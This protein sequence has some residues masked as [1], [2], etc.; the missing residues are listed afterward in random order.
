MK[1]KIVYLTVNGVKLKILLRRGNNPIIILLHGTPGQMSNWKHVLGFLET[2]NYTVVVPD[3]RGYGG[4]EKPEVVSIDDYVEDL[5]GIMESLDLD[6]TMTLVAG[7]SF[8]CVVAME[9]IAKYNDIPATL[10]VGPPYELKMDFI[11]KIIVHTPPLFWKPLFFKNNPLTRRLYR[12]LFFSP[13][14]PNKIFQDFM[15]DN[16]KYIENLPAHVFRYS[17]FF[18][19]WR[20][21]EK[22][23]EARV[24]AEIIVGK[25]DIVTSPETAEKINEL[26]PGSKLITVEDAGHM[27]LYEKPDVV[28]SSIIRLANSI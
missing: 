18:D 16:T 17:R 10:L 23:R 8:G 5:R 22:L 20:A 7:H 11:D 26:I 28:A 25:D 4:S 27:I 21:P 6:P 13:K 1:P 12:K 24:K 3:M 2:K 15:R 9:Y 19:G 14:T